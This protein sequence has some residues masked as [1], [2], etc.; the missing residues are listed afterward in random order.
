MKTDTL[1]GNLT[2]QTMT[3]PESGE[4]KKHNGRIARLLAQVSKMADEHARYKLDKCAW[5][6]IAI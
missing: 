1:E 5:R 2:E 4:G 6:T 3:T